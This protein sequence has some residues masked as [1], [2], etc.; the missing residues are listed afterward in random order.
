MYKACAANNKKQ[1]SLVFNIRK[2]IKPQKQTNSSSSADATKLH[3]KSERLTPFGWNIFSR[4][5]NFPQTVICNSIPR[6]DSNESGR[7]I[8]EFWCG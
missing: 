1:P 6:F 5:E 7:C 4:G 3:I 8:L 2:T